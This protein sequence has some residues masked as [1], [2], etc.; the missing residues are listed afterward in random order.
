V[1]YSVKEIFLTLQGEGANAGRT[2]VFCRFA[3][4]NLWNGIE[5]DRL[6]ATCRFCDTDFRGTDGPGGGRYRSASELA[7]AI[8]GLWPERAVQP[9]VVLTGGEPALQIDAELLDEL[10]ERRAVRAIETNG[11]LELPEG[12]DWV[13]VSPK[14]GAALRVRSGDELKVVHPQPGLDLAALAHLDFR[15]R[16]LQPMD[17]PD[18]AANLRTCVDYC[19][20]DPAW[21]LSIQ[22]HKLIGI[23]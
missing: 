1:S 3:G 21:R 13:C 9:L 16:F 7:E 6:S 17:G 14:A 15:W 8:V 22:S 20:R 10:G 5:R 12:L 2:A 18:A 11:T 4:C 23:P 19:L